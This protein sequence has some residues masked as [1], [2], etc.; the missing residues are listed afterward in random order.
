VSI[1]RARSL[2]GRQRAAASPR[3]ARLGAVAAAVIARWE[4]GIP[5]DESDARDLFS[6]HGLSGVADAVR[7]EVARQGDG[8]AGM[9]VASQRAAQRVSIVAIRRSARGFGL[10]HR[11]RVEAEVRRLRMAGWRHRRQLERQVRKARRD[12]ER[13]ARRCQ[14][15]LRAANSTL[16]ATDLRGKA[17][18]A[19]TETCAS[20]WREIEVL[21][22][23]SE[24]E[25]MEREIQAI[26]A[27]CLERVRGRPARA[28]GSGMRRR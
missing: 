19:I 10:R 22:V 27:R 17:F 21:A 11:M 23:G 28:W 14:R 12:A 16:V 5:V 24:R 20:A 8:R 26:Q 4:S 13:I 3:V 15:E 7:E 9:A 18:A 2:R 25:A 1:D 6:S